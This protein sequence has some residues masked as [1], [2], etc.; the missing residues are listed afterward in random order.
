[1]TFTV[2]PPPPPGKPRAFY[3]TECFPNYWLL[4]LR[5]RGGVCYTFR[6][7]A[8][9]ALSHDDRAQ[10]L[11][12][13]DLF[14]TVSFNGNYYDVPMLAAALSGYTVEQLKWLNDMIIVSRMKPW[15]LN[16]PRWSPPDHIDVMEV[17]PG[18][19]GMKKKAGI[20][21]YK[22]MRDLPYPPDTVLQG[23]QFQVVDEYC[24][25]DL[26]ELEA[27]HDAVAPQLKLREALGARYSLDLRSKSDAQLAEAVIRKRCEL[28]TGNRIYAPDIDYSYSFRFDVPPFI[29][30]ELPQLRKALEIVRNAIFRIGPA[31]NVVAPPEFEELSI[32]IGQSTY[33][34]G[35]G[36]LHSTEKKVV[37]RADDYY[38]L[39]DND[40]ASYYPSLILNSGAWPE[41]LGP[42]FLQEYAAI[43]SERLDA[44]SL[45]KKLEKA[46]LAG[47]PEHEDAATMD[48]G[49]KIMINGVFGKTLGAFGVLRAPKMGIQTTVSGQLSL[50]M[51]IEWHEF[52]GIP[53]VSANTDGIVIKC[54]RHRVADS[55]YLI[56]EWQKRTGLEM[57]TAEYLAVYSR[58]INNY[59]AVKAKFDQATKQWTREPAG[60]KRKGEYAP[61]SLIFKK[62]PDCEICSDAVAEFLEKG[63]SVAETI[64]GC[65][66]IRKFVTIQKVSGGAIKLWGVGPKKNAQL[67]RDIVPTLEANGWTKVDR[68]NWSRGSVVA[69]AGEAYKSCFSPQRPEPLG[70]VIRWYY[71]TQAPG[72]IVWAT[73]GN[74]VGLSEGARPCMILPD[75]F[76]DDVDYAWYL[77]KADAILRDIGYYN[78]C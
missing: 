8:G 32:T 33:T 23:E 41:A 61:T 20:I 78:L 36:G 72:P 60:V 14:T 67:R 58:D 74:H 50:L 45:A 1:M 48:G 28:A 19:G 2:P 75:E 55:E 53:V 39:R 15:E 37:H 7:Y 35:I 64:L 63:T 27:L 18:D 5:P 47:T 16:V 29:S 40:V 54:P 42:M 13:F 9:Q 21:H 62:S 34:M 6:A 65:R 69:A 43:K 22:S 56:Q 3:D 77:A 26:G 24:E 12:L 73:N 4:K 44:K 30:Y 76:P 66:D 11:R 70:K 71:S 25:N 52:N 49:G 17:I 68:A 51:L 38:C 46:G 10:I 59:I 31:G 57:E